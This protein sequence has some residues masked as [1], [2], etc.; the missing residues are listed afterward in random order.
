M[1]ASS[2]TS[3]FTNLHKVLKKHYKPVSADAERPVLEHLLFG[4]CLE[5]TSYQTAEE[6]FAA[7]VEE[8][9]DWNEIRV[10]SVRELSEVMAGLPDARSASF[11]LKRVLQHVFEASYEFN[12]EDLRKGNLG[13]TVERLKKIDGATPFAVSYVVQSAL[14]G[15]SIP[16][17]AGALRLLHILDLI[18]DKDVEKGVAPG[19]ERAVVK[20]K[21]V[22][23]GSLLHQFAADLSDNPYSPELHAVLLEIN[24]QCKSR[25]PKRHRRKPASE[26]PAK[27]P[28][29]TSK[30]KSQ[31]TK[32]DTEKA[33][34]KTAA[35]KNKI[36]ARKK[37]TEKTEKKAAKKKPT[38]PKKKDGSA[39]V[40]REG[41]GTTKASSA[42]IAK[43]K[44]R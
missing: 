22:E 2:R 31:P 32:A 26:T 35:P 36:T 18:T 1:A 20:S 41:T 15:H 34:K 10:S 4:C 28:A 29:K 7:L 23:F 6:A 9:F 19:L 11:R 27:A 5:D 24:P 42:T 43:R 25:L 8:M 44:P 37:T 30:K 3:Q 17:D 16:I 14:G 21:G 33:A 12:L 38:S 39:K 40:K 13:P